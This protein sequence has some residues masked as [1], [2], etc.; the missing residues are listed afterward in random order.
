M[1]GVLAYRTSWE[2]GREQEQEQEQD[3]LSRGCRSQGSVLPVQLVSRHL[4]SCWL[5]LSLHG[6]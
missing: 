3:W 2:R 1:A 5:Q 4:C 6:Y